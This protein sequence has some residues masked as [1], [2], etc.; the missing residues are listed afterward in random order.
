MLLVSGW[1]APV[2]TSLPFPTVNFSLSI[3]ALRSDDTME[4]FACLLV[5]SFDHCP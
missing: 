3:S 5:P 2:T 1:M 4:N